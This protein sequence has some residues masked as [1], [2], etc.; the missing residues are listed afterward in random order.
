MRLLAQATLGRKKA[1]KSRRVCDP[2]SH[3]RYPNPK[4]DSHFHEVAEQ[5][6]RA[7]E[8]MQA[9]AGDDE[10]VRVGTAEHR[11]D[12]DPED[13]KTPKDEKV[14]PPGGPLGPRIPAHEFLLPKGVDQHGANAFGNA[15]EAGHGDGAPQ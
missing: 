6:I 7:A 10:R 2:P 13:T 12:L 5:Q 9:K 3:K 1:I 4:Q 11:E 15:I 14:H 8:E